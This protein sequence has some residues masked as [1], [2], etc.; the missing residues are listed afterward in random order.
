M[1]T[2]IL[3]MDK[4]FHHYYGLCVLD[5]LDHETNRTAMGTPEQAKKM[6]TLTYTMM[7]QERVDE[8]GVRFH[9][10]MQEVSGYFGFG[11][12]GR[13]FETVKTLY[14]VAHT[15]MEQRIAGGAFTFQP[16]EFED[17]FSPRNL[18]DSRLGCTMR[19][20]LGIL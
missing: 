18:I 5:A 12:G 11:E 15:H 1:L 7:S 13:L 19:L 8:Y 16:E 4:P 20:G 6:R 9:E 2:N 17:F 10:Y 14:T 3:G